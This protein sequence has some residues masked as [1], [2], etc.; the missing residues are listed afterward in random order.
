VQ[1]YEN[2]NLKLFAAMR[3]VG[4]ESTLT[5]T[6]LMIRIVNASVSLFPDEAEEVYGVFIK[7]T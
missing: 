3:R 5:Q 2:V 7:T 4:L 6:P 1:P